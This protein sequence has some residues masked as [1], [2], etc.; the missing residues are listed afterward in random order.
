LPFGKKKSKQGASRLPDAAP[1]PLP[2]RGPLGG[3]HLTPPVEHPTPPG[4]DDVSAVKQL[5]S[6]GFSRTQ[7]VEALEKYDYDVQR[8]LNNLLG[9][10]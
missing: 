10:S 7:A 6:M 9:T 8:A 1:P 4:E 2:S 3:S 5:C